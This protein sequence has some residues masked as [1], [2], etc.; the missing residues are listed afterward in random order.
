MAQ[1]IHHLSR[2]HRLSNQAAGA[3]LLA[4]VIVA[5]LG[6]A[7]CGSVGLSNYTTPP[8]AGRVLA[9]DTRQPL[10]GVKVIRL[11]PGQSAEAGSPANGAQLLLQGRPEL[12]GA[13]G[14]F[15]LPGRD[16]VSFI[17]HSG[18][19]SV[20]LA[21]QAAHYA[22]LQT[23]YTESDITTNSPLAV[24]EVKAGDILLKPLSK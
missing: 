23:N 24:P 14:S 22:T 15:V 18:R 13:D 2:H 8:V 9:E 1:K 10:A 11:Q 3:L 17:K 12:T 4:G 21:F 20:R 5:A 7:G 6:A 19:W 16:Y